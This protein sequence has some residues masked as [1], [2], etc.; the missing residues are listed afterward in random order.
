MGEH[1]P[2]TQI[3]RISEVRG[4]FNSLVNQV[5]RKE[6][7]VLVE[8]SGIPVAGLV[9]VD[10]LR[11]LDKLDRERA[12]KFSVVEEMRSAFQ[13]VPATE[14]EREAE[15]TIAEVRSEQDKTGADS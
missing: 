4:Q 5:Y 11:R 15:R 14:I 12:E 10:D 6:T 13:D 2:E 8:K 9:S 1:Q 3:M 7:R